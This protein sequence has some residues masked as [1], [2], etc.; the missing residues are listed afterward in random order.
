MEKKFNSWYNE[1]ESGLFPLFNEFAKYKH[2]FFA[3]Y[4]AAQQSV[5]RTAILFGFIGLGFGIVVGAWI[6]VVTQ[7]A[8]R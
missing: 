1:V 5:Y 6:T 2:S 7:I 8:T 3:G 4:K